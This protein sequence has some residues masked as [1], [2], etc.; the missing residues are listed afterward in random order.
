[1]SHPLD[2]SPERIAAMFDDIAPHY[3]FLN[4]FLSLN[5][6]KC[7]RRTLTR[8]IAR[9]HPASIL[10]VATGTGDLAI[11]LHRRT[12]AAVTGIDI[13]EGM[14]NIAKRKTQNLARRTAKPPNPQKG[15]CPL[16]GAFV[17]PLEIRGRFNWLLASAE[18]MPFLDGSFDA[19]TVAFGVRNI[20]NLAAGLQ[21]MY[22]VLKPAGVVAV[23]EFSTPTAFPVKQ[24]YRF[25][26]HYVLPAIGRLFSKHR[27]A[28][29]Y[30]PASADA[31]PTG[32]TFV[33]QLQ[34]AGFTDVQSKRLSWG[35]AML[36]EGVKRKASR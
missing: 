2:K 4:H 33:K 23:L 36:Y 26:F 14:L 9:R 28:Y 1:M 22:R 29:R 25:Y 31:F 11:A 7:W 13:S 16:P 6:D 8:R 20:D 35:I 24:A 34:Q 27:T 3:D 10:D 21:E 12:A 18:A 5:I 30:L 19:V 15:N 17:P 32:D